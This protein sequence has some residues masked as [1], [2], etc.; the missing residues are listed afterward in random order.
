MSHNLDKTDLKILQILQ[1]NGRITNL[2]LSNEIGLSPA[3]TLE[4][5]RKLEKKGLIT[6]YHANANAEKLG[7]GIKALI[8]ISLARQMENAIAHF[9][10]AINEIP[11]IVECY[12]VTGKFDY[13]MMIMVEDIQAFERL[14]SQKLSKIDE[15]GEMESYV[16]LSTIKKSHVIP[17]QYEG[18]DD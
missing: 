9:T 11:E 13:Q 5:V 1:E 6:S 3:P 2:Q 4:R 17:L 10:R 12:Q 7:I 15:I 8:Q 16:I 18:E 14:I